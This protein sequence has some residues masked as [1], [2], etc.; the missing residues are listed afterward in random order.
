LKLTL[1]SSSFLLKL[2]LIT[3]L[4]TLSGCVMLGG[5]QAAVTNTC[6]SNADCDG[7]VCAKAFDKRVCVATKADLPGLILEVRPSA[8]ASYGAGTSF[9]MP[10]SGAGLVDQS[11]TGLVVDHDLDLA[12]VNISPLSLFVD[13]DYKS[14]PL[15]PG[16][17]LPADFTFYRTSDIAGLPEYEATAFAID[18]ETASFAIDL[19]A[20]IYD[21]HVVPRAPAGCA[22]DPPPPTF[23]RSVD[24]SKSGNIDL[25]LTLAPRIIKGTIGFP[26]G[27]DLTG[28]TIEVVEP[29][30]GLVVSRSQVLSV[31]P[32]SLYADYELPYYWEWGIESSPVLRLRPPDGV[33]APKLFWEIAALSP[34]NPND[35]VIEANL[36]L[37]DLD[38]VGRD[39]E[40]YVIGAD[41]KTVVAT[42]ELRSTGLSGNASNNAKYSV[43]V[44]TDEDGRF[45]T[46]LPPGTYKVTARPTADPTKA[47][48][49]IDWDISQ[50][51]SGCFCGTSI[52]LRDKSVVA[53]SVVLPNG[54]PLSIGT[55][56]VYPSRNPEK[57]YLSSKLI[58][59]AATSQPNSTP[60]GPLGDFSLLTDPGLVDLTVVPPLGSSYPWLVRSQLKPNDNAI[61]DLQTLTVS[62]PVML[63]GLVRDPSGQIVTN[64]T[65]RA[66]MPVKTTRMGLTEMVVVQV[67]DGVTGADGRYA[68]PIAPSTLSK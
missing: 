63:G 2:L 29:K 44:D 16:G 64:A 65:V 8:E 62:Y 31:T 11:D 12:E 47:V 55:A 61:F 27:Q 58:A 54:A 39:V 23:H 53:G 33:D 4:P 46:K 68:L 51:E 1:F 43:L 24:L 20:A 49:T 66:W 32:L 35:A 56:S 45:V 48:T 60:L 59:D 18:G 26:Q 30:H 52:V 42:V 40:A 19:P 17:K 21:I 22:A 7:G 15:L 3:S 10:F 57:P 36:A 13:Y 6:S 5:D 50:L 14:C 41:E 67:A 28:W 9:L 38:A 37:V 25:R 34:L